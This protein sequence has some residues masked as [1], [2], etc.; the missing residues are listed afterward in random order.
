M[1][2]GPLTCSAYGWVRGYEPACSNLAIGNIIVLLFFSELRL[3]FSESIFEGREGPDPPNSPCNVMVQLLD[4]SIA[5]PVT[6]R[7]IP[8]T[9]D[10]SAVAIGSIGNRSASSTYLY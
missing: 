7:F 6:L 9:F 10:E 4:I 2:P 3:G 5:N 8:Q 1:S